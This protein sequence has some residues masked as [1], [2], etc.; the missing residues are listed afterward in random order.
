MMMPY[1]DGTGTI[2]ALQK[3]DPNVKIIASS[4]LADDGKAAEA[5][6]AGVKIFL[7]KP[8]TAEE[9]LNAIAETLAGK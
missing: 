3:M 1:L 2:R 6:A 4:G 7:S 8:Y 9:L 5:G